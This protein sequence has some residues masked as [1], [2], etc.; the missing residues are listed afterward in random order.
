[1][2]VEL[3]TVRAERD[4]LRGALADALAELAQVRTQLADTHAQLAAVETDRQHMRQE[5]VDLKRKP[6]GA[7][8][9][10]ADAPV[11]KPR[12]RAAGHVGSGR[13]RPERID[14]TQSISAG[15][16][17]PECV[18]AFTGRGT[19]RERVIEDIELVRPTVVTKYLIERRWCPH[20]RRYHED[21][22]VAALPRH[23]LGLH[24]LLVRRLPEGRARPQLY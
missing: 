19:T 6:F 14:R 5:L 11:A 16:S 13:Q 3:A 18:T 4:Q 23:R 12:G 15:E 2:R 21:A 9:R 1:M 10:P 7:P 20:C 8:G 17:C 24:V 22:V